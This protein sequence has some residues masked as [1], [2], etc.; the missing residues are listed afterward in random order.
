MQSVLLVLK[1]NKKKIKKEKTLQF[2]F[3]SIFSKRDEI[4]K[5]IDL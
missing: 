1:K 2:L 4:S 3:F 5:K